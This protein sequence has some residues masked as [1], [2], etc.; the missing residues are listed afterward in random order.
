MRSKGALTGSADLSDDAPTVVFGGTINLT[1]MG[2]AVGDMLVVRDSTEADDVFL[3][4]TTYRITEVT[5]STTLQVTPNTVV[6]TI[7]NADWY[8][9]RGY[10]TYPTAVSDPTNYPYG[11]DM[12]GKVANSSGEFSNSDPANL[13]ISG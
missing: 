2:V 4:N 3:Q 12:Y 7:A 6:A 13:L 5:D 8:I 1:T 9:C 10:T 11:G